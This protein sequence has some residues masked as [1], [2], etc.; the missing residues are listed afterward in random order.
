MNTFKI[1]K[2]K[3]FLLF[4]LPLLLAGCE[5]ELSDDVVP[6]RF[7]TTGEI[8]TDNFVGMGQDFYLPFANSKLDAFSVDNDEGFESSAS[9]RVDVPN[10]SDPTGNYAG[11]IL[12]IDGAGRDLSGYDALS[13]YAKASQGITISEVGFGQDFFENKYQVHAS[14]L[15]VGTTWRKYIIPIPDPEKLL[16]ERGVFWYSD[17]T[18][19]TNGK[20]YTL[21]FDEIKF[22]NLGTIAHPRPAILDGEDVIVQSFIGG[23]T[24]VDGLTETFNLANGRDVTI[25]VA[26]SYFTFTSSDTTVATVDDLG[27]VTV[28]DVNGS[29]TITASLAG[30]EAIGSLTLESQGSFIPAPAP[31]RDPAS[32]ISI[33]SDAYSNEPVDFFNGF[34]EPFQTTTSNDFSVNGDN[35]L[36][37]ENFNFVGIE[38]NQ[39]VPTINGKLATHFHTDIFVPG[40]IP[41]NAE[42]RI[43]IADFGGDGAFGGDDDTQILEDFALGST[44]DQWIS[45]DMDITGLNPKTSLGQIVLSGDGPG[46]PPS[47]F[48]ADNLY[49]YREDGTN[50]TP[51]A[52]TLPIDFELSNPSNYVFSGFEGAESAIETN[53]DQTGVNTSAT[54]MRTTKMM[55]AQF[56]AG[57][58]IDVDAP[59]DLSQTQR[60]SMKVWSPKADIP[61]GLALE[62]N[63]GGADQVLVEVNTTTS[64]EWE[65]LVFDFGGSAD[66]SANYNRV[67]V[68]ME[69]IPD[70][71]GDG[72][73]YYFDDIQLAN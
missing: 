1:F 3:Q 28:V 36:N 39:N 14:G 72:S 24:R 73:T 62:R 65:E 12:R 40:S 43:V 45:L 70:L 44:A 22:E 4:T 38:F 42:L 7:S 57:T 69:F 15:D 23:A 19:E 9:Y 71:A 16:Q 20:G 32:V 25:N 31:T 21:W 52:V 61:V 29:A 27:S 8:F 6:A 30:T 64:N 51:E 13:F 26:P 67:I 54:V 50:I 18:D 63:D 53:P 66:N 10:A 47:N 49:F 68:F 60:F 34:Y 17:G 37:Y 11:A 55:G 33:F 35:L 2:A 46:T 5:R 48:Y 56:F 41:A 59:I 58:L